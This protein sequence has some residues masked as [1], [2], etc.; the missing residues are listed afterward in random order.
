MTFRSDIR[1][2]NQTLSEGL[3]SGLRRHKNVRYVQ[4]SASVSPGSSGGG[5][6]DQ[7]ANLVGIM[8]FLLE[9][10][11]NLNFAIAAEE[12]WK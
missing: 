7:H 6:F 1:C 2:C 4:T 8:T 11:Q 10:G 9:G 3:I 12:F 5:L